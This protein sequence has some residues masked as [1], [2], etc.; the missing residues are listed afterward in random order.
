L[1]GGGFEVLREPALVGAERD[2]EGLRFG[3]IGLGARCGS[4]SLA[5]G[6]LIDGIVALAPRDT[7]PAGEVGRANRPQ[8]EVG[9]FLPL[10]SEKGCESIGAEKGGG[11]S[12]VCVETFGNLVRWHT[13]QPGLCPTENPAE[14]F[15]TG[16][17]AQQMGQGSL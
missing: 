2:P 13:W 14:Q 9:P 6:G 8:A 7:L 15:R 3:D 11:P 10:D 17:E 5:L 4:G 16:I 12:I 1:D